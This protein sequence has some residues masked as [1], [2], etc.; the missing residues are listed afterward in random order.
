[1]KSKTSFINSGI[2]HNDFKNYGWIAVVY[3]LGLLLAIPLKIIMLHSQAQNPEIIIGSAQYLG[4]FKFDSAFQIMLFI[5]IPIMTGLWLFRYLQENNRND[6]IHALPVKRVTLYNTHIFSGIVLLSLPLLITALVSWILVAGMG[7]EYISGWQILR[8]FGSSLLFNLIFFMVTVITGICTGISTLQG[9]L[10]LIL[11]VLPTGLFELLVVNARFFFYGFTR[12]FY[13]AK[14]VFSPLLRMGDLS[15]VPLQAGE[16]VA[17]LLTILILFV[18]GSYL[19]QQRHLERAGSAIAFDWLRPVFKYGVTFCFML[20]LGAYFYD[21]Q[22]ASLTWMYFGYFLGSLLAYF[23]V[24]ILLTK[25]TRVWHKQALKGY[26]IYVLVMLIVIGGLNFDFTGFERRQPDLAKVESIYLDRSFYN[27]READVN[28][29]ASVQE[30]EHA[31]WLKP[32]PCNFK[33]QTNLTNIYALH[34]KIIE[35][36]DRDRKLINIPYR[37]YQHYEEVCLVYNMKNGQHIY[38]QYVLPKDKYRDLLKPIYESPEAKLL[39]N[40]IFRIDTQQIKTLAIHGYDVS[41]KEVFISDP[42]LIKQAVA[43]LKKEILKQSYA[44]MNSNKVPWA[45]IALF[46]NDQQRI[47]V[48]WQKSFLEFEQWLIE[49][50]KRDQARVIANQDIEYAVVEKIPADNEA[51]WRTLES[52]DERQAIQ[53]MEKRPG[54]LKITDTDKLEICLNNYINVYRPVYNIRFLLKNGQTL[55]GGFSE[56][57]VPDFIK[58]HF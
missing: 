47:H 33:D 48:A 27:L 31:Y 25:S 39:Q 54:T 10:T 44:D 14:T 20:L 7:I 49:I 18:L 35:N 50:D 4:I 15:Y 17:Y 6:M 43:I 12:D 19:Y 32:V 21:T 55:S 38:R 58:E 3:L 56:N 52:K 34:Q 53:E 5:L 23:L 37:H 30:T 29:R 46:K 51:A 40:D 8:W 57:D 9:I 1:M 36:R 11:L 45:E 16:V 2:L 13:S 26:G 28:R 42:Q 41:D 22:Q 24:E